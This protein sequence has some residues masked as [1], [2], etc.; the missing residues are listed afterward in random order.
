[1]HNCEKPIANYDEPNWHAVSAIP[2]VECQQPL[3]VL[4]LSPAFSVY[5]AYH[6]L[7]VPNA[8]A[9]CYARSEVFE[10]LLEVTRLLP[11]GTRL[12][13]LD[14]WRPF[15]VQQYLYESLS[16]ALNEYY[17]DAD[18]AQLEHLTRQYV[19]PPSTNRT[20]P[21]P[22]LT[23]G[24]VDVTLCDAEGRFL[25]M[26][27]EFDEA[28]PLSSTA[29]FE[30]IEQPNTRQT[31]VR[32]NRRI[33][34]NAMLAAGFSNLPSEWWHYDFGDQLWAWSCSQPQAIYGPSQIQSLDNLWRQQLEQQMGKR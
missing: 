31:L 4:G 12:V 25:D 32:K 16:D 17:P 7:G 2:I 15:A 23:G 10:R 27:T 26:G 5:P 33:L 22:H 13:I 8:I 9:E 21:S 29:A 28:S 34:Y 1:M 3:Q 6:R 20:A 30:L 19:S 11:A 14:A 24:A 18:N